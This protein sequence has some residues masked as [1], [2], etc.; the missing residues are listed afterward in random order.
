MKIDL[1]IPM[2]FTFLIFLLNLANLKYDSR[3]IYHE[4]LA[5]A[6]T[7][8]IK[9]YCI[10]VY[11]PSLAGQSQ[12]HAAPAAVMH[13]SLLTDCQAVWLLVGSI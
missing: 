10:F 1:C 9:M 12:T 8:L 11:E 2:Q 6:Q 7:Y 5:K 13:R 3:T 4:T